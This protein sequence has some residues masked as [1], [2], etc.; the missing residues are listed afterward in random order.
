MTTEQ[1]I[2][3]LLAFIDRISGQLA[4]EKLR[5]ADLENEQEGKS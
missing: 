2:Q 4:A 3:D 1:E 5:L